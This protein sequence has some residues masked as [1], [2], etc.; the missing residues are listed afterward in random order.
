MLPI[1]NNTAN[2]PARSYRLTANKV[3][4]CTMPWVPPTPLLIWTGPIPST[5]RFGHFS[6]GGVLNMEYIAKARGYLAA[7]AV[8]TAGHAIIYCLQSK[9]QSVVAIKLSDYLTSGI[10]SH[11]TSCMYTGVT[12]TGFTIYPWSLVLLVIRHTRN[13][14]IWSATLKMITKTFLQTK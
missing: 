8:Q 7:R 13:D 6:E 2:R 9:W 4:V 12:M 1:M 5:L 11:K 10:F 14:P 3:T